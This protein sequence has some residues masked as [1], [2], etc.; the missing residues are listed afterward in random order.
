V[1]IRTANHRIT[2]FSDAQSFTV[3]SGDA[4]L[5]E[6]QNRDWRDRSPL[7]QSRRLPLNVIKKGQGRYFLDFGKAAFATLAFPNYSPA[8]G[9]MTIHLGEVLAAPDSLHRLPGGSRRYRKLVCEC[10]DLNGAILR[11]PPDQRNT[12][13]SA[14]LVPPSFH[15]VLPFRYVELENVPAQ[16]RPEQV[17]QLILHYPFDEKAADFSCS[18][19][20]LNDIWD[21]CKYS[22]KATSFLGVYIDGDRERIPYEGDAYINQLSHYAVDAEYAMPRHTIQYLFH[23]PTWPVEWQQHMV[24]MAWA[25]FMYTG[26]ADLLAK[27]YNDLSAKTLLALAREDGL[28]IEDRSLMSEDLLHS[29]RLSQPPRVLVDWP[30]ADFTKNNRYGERDG[31]DMKPVNTVANAFHYQTLLLMSR[32]ATVL[33]KSDDAKLWQE[34]ASRVR[35]AFN[36]LFF[37]A[38]RGHYIDGEASEH[39]ALHANFFPLAFGLVDEDN[40]AAVARF[41]KSRGMACSVYGAQHLLDALYLAGEADYA[42]ELLT[43]THDRSWAHMIYDMGSTITTEAWDNKYKENQD[44]NHAWGAAPGNIISRRLMGIQPADPGFKCVRIHPQLGALTHARITVPTLRGTIQMRVQQD[45][46]RWQAWIDIPAQ[47]SAEIVVP[48]TEIDKIL[49]NRRR[50]GPDR[51][52]RVEHGGIVVPVA[53]G[54]FHYRVEMKR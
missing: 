38:A 8:S 24:L 51:A 20:I 25:D 13:G 11:M 41:I 5:F 15:E 29:L 9:T 43:A 6:R 45:S 40:V 26:Q 42:L 16:L 48:A 36:R 37:D 33:N 39:S 18:S 27:Y 3:V 46:R 23:H 31:Y 34:R 19:T 4:N 32:I 14:V 21:L 44:W 12:S 22:I 17:E 47:M 49:E 28:I 50:L 7:C 35:L 53:C 10:S 1:R 54:H 30:P 2:P 52:V